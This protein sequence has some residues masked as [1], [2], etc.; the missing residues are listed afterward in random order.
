[1]SRKQAAAFCAESLAGQVLRAIA[2]GDLGGKS[3]FSALGVDRISDETMS[4]YNESDLAFYYSLATSFA[5][6]DRY[7]SSTL[8]PTFPNRSYL[9][10]ATSFGHLTTDEIVPP[11]KPVA[12]YQP[13]TGTIFDQLD[14]HGVLWADY[15]SDIPQGI[16][17]RNFLAD[18]HFR[19]AS[20]V[21]PSRKRT[22]GLR[23]L[24]RAVMRP[25]MR[26]QSRQLYARITFS[27]R[28]FWRVVGGSFSAH[29]SSSSM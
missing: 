6:D 28:N 5:L 12:V 2:R 29:S 18:R 24:A 26:G 13:F 23:I 25:W 7:F 15:F 19:Q 27:P 20:R 16:S 14:A 21:F 8:G 9:M 17:F 22:K 11:G 4:F 10:A 3:A 1:V